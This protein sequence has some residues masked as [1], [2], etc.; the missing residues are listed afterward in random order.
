MMIFL[1]VIIFSIYLK[2]KEENIIKHFLLNTFETN[3][4]LRKFYK[5]RHNNV[6]NV[7]LG[8]TKVKDDKDD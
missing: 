1:K 4:F 7:L 3:I 6:R 8:W 2:W 5:E